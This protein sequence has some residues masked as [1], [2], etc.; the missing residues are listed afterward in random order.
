MKRIRLFGF[1]SCLVFLLASCSES[2]EPKKPEPQKVVQEPVAKP[3]SKPDCQLNM[4]WDPW[5]PYQYLTPE[6]EVKGLEIDLVSAMAKEAGCDLKF[7]QQN[8]M[9]LLNGIRNGSIDLL[10]GASKTEA[11]EAF[12]LFS[13][14]YRSESFVLYIRKGESAKYADKS[15]QELLEGT[16]R[17]GVTDDYIYGEQVTKLQ[18]NPSFKGKFVSVPTTEM[19]Y[20]N[21]IQNHIEG[22]L[23]DPFVAAY[24]IKRKG[25]QDQIEAL[26]ITIHSG[27]VALMFSQ[28]SVKPETVVAFNDALQRLKDSGEYQQILDKY[29]F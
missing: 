17:L 15:L 1:L 18:D 2:P 20:Y 10:G 3:P 29:S 14:A 23:E 13:D 12:A 22:F 5:E 25:L 7:V 11:R 26:P 4:G 16:F 19:N 21:L 9:T 28:K 27:D 24:T 6:D 8:W